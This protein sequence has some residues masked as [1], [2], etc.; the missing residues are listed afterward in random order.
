MA[1]WLSI[2]DTRTID[3]SVADRDEARF[4]DDPVWVIRVPFDGQGRLR[5]RD[6]ASHA[7]LAGP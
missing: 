4:D 5:G 6:C 1:R 2:T 3:P 7:P